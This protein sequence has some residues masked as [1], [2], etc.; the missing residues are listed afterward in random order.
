MKKLIIALA[1]ILAITAFGNPPLELEAELNLFELPPGS[2]QNGDV[3]TPKCVSC[4]CNK[5]TKDADGMSVTITGMEIHRGDK[6]LPDAEIS[7]GA[8]PKGSLTG[9]STT[10]AVSRDPLEIAHAFKN[11]HGLDIN[12]A[13]FT[14]VFTNWTTFQEIN[15]TTPAHLTVMTYDTKKQVGQVQTNRVLS[16]HYAGRTNEIVLDVIGIEDRPSKF[17]E[18]LVPARHRPTPYVSYSIEVGH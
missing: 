16:I 15:D 1:G 6:N 18:E 13:V 12:A 8:V 9:N 3:I 4:T 7:W 11:L 17:R 5:P 14:N 2:I 10:F